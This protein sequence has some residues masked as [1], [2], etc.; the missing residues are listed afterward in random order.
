MKSS[1]HCIYSV[2]QLGNKLGL[3]WLG[4][5]G[6][7]VFSSQFYKDN[8]KFRKSPVHQNPLG[9]CVYFYSVYILNI[10]RPI[11]LDSSRKVVHVLI[12]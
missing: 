2:L 7:T 10:C 8:L 1:Q 6:G 11:E 9:S 3:P 4:I 12:S 5:R